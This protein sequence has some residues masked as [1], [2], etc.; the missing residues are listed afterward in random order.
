MHEISSDLPPGAISLR[1]LRLWNRRSEA[2]RDI[3]SFDAL[4]Q[5][6][7]DVIQQR[8]EE[9]AWVSADATR[10]ASELIYDESAP[11]GIRSP[12][13]IRENEL[14]DM[15]VTREQVE[16]WVVRERIAA[17]ENGWAVSDV[18]PRIRSRMTPAPRVRR[19]V[20]C[21][22]RSRACRRR[23]RRAARAPDDPSRPSF[24]CIAAGSR[25]G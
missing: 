14:S 6:C 21:V 2:F 10:A 18:I 7:V 20:R 23:V 17:V 15:G 19:P 12:S 16:Y 22:P 9:D 1:M 11:A 25:D 13:Q 5:A 4:A 3:S 8:R 24:S